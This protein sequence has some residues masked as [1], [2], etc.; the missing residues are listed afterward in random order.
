MAWRVKHSW[1]VVAANDRIISPDLERL[2]AARMN[3]VT[4]TVP[5]SQV[6]MLA[7]PTIVATF[8]EIA[9]NQVFKHGR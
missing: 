1:F 9:A 4:I 2:E 5:T 6:A 8:I 3:A 7:E